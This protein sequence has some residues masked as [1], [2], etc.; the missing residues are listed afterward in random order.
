[1][2]SNTLFRKNAGRFASKSI[3]K[4]DPNIIFKQWENLFAELSTKN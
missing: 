2:I 4:F 3:Q 1:M